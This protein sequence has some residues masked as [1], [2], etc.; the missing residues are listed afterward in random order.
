MRIRSL[1]FVFVFLGLAKYAWADA[2]PKPSMRF[3]LHFEEG[4]QQSFV[5]LIQLQYNY[6]GDTLPADSLH[7]NN[8]K[9]PQGLRC[10]SPIDCRS[11]A[12]GYTEFHKLMFVFNTN[13]TIYSEMFVKRA[14]NSVYEVNVTHGGASVKNITPWFSRDDNPYAFL[15][16][17][18]FTLF[19]EILV[20]SLLLMLFRVLDKRRFLLAIL[21]ANMVSLPVFWFGIMPLFNSSLGFF[22]GE[23]FVVLYEAWFVWVF[24]KKNAPFGKILFLI[25][26]LNLLSM[27][28]GGAFVFF[29]GTFGA[30]IN[31]W[32]I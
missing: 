13:D 3:V 23:F 8:N 29:N 28:A 2:G 6:A 7:D 9:G 16:S 27:M 10:A 22:L 4:L 20:G 30:Q 11:R 1:L 24:T 17:L 21:L 26:F 19:I 31:N 5:R 18:I 25:F 12:Y 15:R 32:F 14:F